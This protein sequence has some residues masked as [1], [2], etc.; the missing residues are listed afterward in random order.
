MR[1]TKRLPPI[2]R[3]T[4]SLSLAWL[5]FCRPAVVHAE[6][7]RPVRPLRE[8]VHLQPG[9]TCLDA[10]VLVEDIQ[11]WLGSSEVDQDLWI[12]VEGSPTDP[13]AVTFRTGRGS[14]LLAQ[15]RFKP[16]PE[17]CAHLHAVLGITIAM[18]VKAS[19]MDE[20][21]GSKVEAP[22]AEHPVPVAPGRPW[23]LGAHLVA[24][25]G[26][27]PGSAFGA[28]VR[29]ERALS[30]TFA[31][32]LGVLGISGPDKS[33][34]QTPG[35]F[36]V[37]LFASRMDACAAAD[38][39]R[40]L[41]VRGCMGLFAGGLVARGKSFEESQSSVLWWF[42]VANELEFATALTR[43]WDLQVAL[44]VALPV[45]PMSIVARSFEGEV[46]DRRDLATVGG[47]TAIGLAHPV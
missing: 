20:L 24:A 30:P 27:V 12:D 43:A 32:R 6:E 16:G 2:E 18:A 23:T 15:R 13:R 37:W 46:L 14:Q 22:V 29:L 28:G 42:A 25:L 7:V 36:D 11:S 4:L 1:R 41:R 17:G 44:G 38:L 39:L 34:G 5:S 8:A 9:A 21:T 33:F 47:F 31:V 10:V 35:T 26:V 19:L 45:Q 3:I 40:G